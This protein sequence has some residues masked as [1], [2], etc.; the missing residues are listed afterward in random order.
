MNPLTIYQDALNR[1]SQAVLVGDFNRY[2]AMIDFPYLVHTRDSDLLVTT[3]AD[4]RPTFFA[5]HDGLKARGVTHYERVAR[6]ADYVDRKRIEGLHHTHML[7]NGTA[8]NLPHVSRQTI[9]RR[10]ELWLFS[11]AHYD[12]VR[13]DRWPLN[14]ADVFAAVDALAGQEA[15]E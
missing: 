4:L 13:G 10:G 2:S 8:V 3:T 1:V 11:E 7:A 5:L 9:V 14:F 12:A 6:S 15:A